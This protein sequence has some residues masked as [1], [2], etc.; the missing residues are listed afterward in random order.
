M[1]NIS[2]HFVPIVLVAAFALI[3]DLNVVKPE[4]AINRVQANLAAAPQRIPDG[5]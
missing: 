4:R 3:A 1:L 5:A 2:F